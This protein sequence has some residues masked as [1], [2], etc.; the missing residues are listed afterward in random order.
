MREVNWDHNPGNFWLLGCSTRVLF[1]F[2]FSLLIWATAQR[3]SSRR[4]E[5]QEGKDQDAHYDTVLPADLSS[6]S[7]CPLHLV[8][9][10]LHF[11]FPQRLNSLK[12]Q[13]LLTQSR[14]FIS[15]R[16]MVGWASPEIYQS[17]VLL[18]RTQPAYSRLSRTMQRRRKP[19]DP[20][21]FSSFQ[22]SWENY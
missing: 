16:K 18:G 15:A 21:L 1:W 5:V 3:A 10:P 4:I 8:P 20:V 6:I 12:S 9:G 14:V 13:E 2:C 7:S 19:K 22:T 17:G 11:H